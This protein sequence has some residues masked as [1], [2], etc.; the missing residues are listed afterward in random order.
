MRRRT[1][2]ALLGAGLA[3]CVSGGPASTADEPTAAGSPRGTQASPASEGPTDTSTPNPSRTP[4][5]PG[6]SAFA[7]ADCPRVLD[8]CYHRA[9]AESRAYVR[10]SVERAPAPET[11]A[12][13]LLNRSDVSLSFGPYHWRIW[14]KGGVGWT[15]LGPEEMLDL[16]AIVEPGQ[17]YSWTAVLDPEGGEVLPGDR[18]AEGSTVAFTPGRYCFGIDV[19][20]ETEEWTDD[21]RDPLGT[22]GCLFAVTEN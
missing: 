6:D 9:T 3:G 13:T 18:S 22:V 14:R 17:S 15:D 5:L 4:P 20:A 11:V 10:P 19:H 1:Y 8:A 7:D 2:A 12:F 21:D 16:G